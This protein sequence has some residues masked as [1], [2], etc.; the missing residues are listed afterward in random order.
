MCNPP[1]PPST[2]PADQTYFL[3]HC[4]QMGPARKVHETYGD[5]EREAER[6]AN[7]HPGKCFYIL[8]AIRL[9]RAKIEPVSFRAL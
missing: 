9:V 8:R 7:L 1:T 2:R 5:A 4:E 6:L 3:V